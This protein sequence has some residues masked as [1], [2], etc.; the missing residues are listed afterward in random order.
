MERARRGVG[1]GLAF[2]RHSRVSW[3]VFVAVAIGVLVA[4]FTLALYKAAAHDRQREVESD[5]DD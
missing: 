1:A 3:I 4:M 5:D 2:A